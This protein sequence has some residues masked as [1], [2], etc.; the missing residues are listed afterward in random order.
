MKQESQAVCIFHSFSFKQ[1][2]GMG[3]Y[4]VIIDT[5]G[6]KEQKSGSHVLVKLKCGNRITEGM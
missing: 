3:T 6:I 1:K 4:E 5:S 2:T